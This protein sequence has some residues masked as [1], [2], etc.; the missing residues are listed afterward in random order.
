MR[1]C[2]E[3][4]GAHTWDVMGRGVDRRVITDLDQPWGE[5]ETC[6]SCG[7]CV[8]VCPTGA[9]FEK[10][11][12]VAEMAQTTAVPALS[13]ADAGGPTMS[14]VRLATVWLDGCSGCHMSFLDLDERLLELAG[15]ID[16]VY[17]P[18]VDAK[19]F[20]AGR[21]RHAG[22]GGGQH[23]ED[24]HKI[25]LIRARTKIL[26]SFGDCAVTGN[27]PAMR[28]PFRRRRRAA[29]GLHRERRRCDAAASP[30]GHAAA[31]A[32]VR[33]VHEAL[34]V[35]VFVPGCPP[36]ADTHLLRSRTNCWRAQ[37]RVRARDAIRIGAA[38]AAKQSSSTP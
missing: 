17:S 32:R 13:D 29:P 16:L 5:S 28:N 14:K 23:E 36:S 25:R 34:P 8:Q 7:K 37:A 12:S 3:I 4:E 26:V 9:L 20:P 24:L 11:R 2:D 18:L 27:V 19:E 22:G 21:G 31:A 10:G 15:D 6:T 33:P 1:V 38:I 35:D 30:S